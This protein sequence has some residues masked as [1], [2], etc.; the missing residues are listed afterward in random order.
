MSLRVDVRANRD[1]FE[2]DVAFE[3]EPGNTVALLGPN[4]SGK[5][6]LVS[7]LAGLLSP[8]EGI[9]HLEDRVLDD[10]AHGVHVDPEDRSVGVVFQDRLLLPHLDATE[11]VAFPLRA[12][13][14]P[15]NEALGRARALLSDLG[16]EARASAMPAELSGGEAQ[17]VALA[18]ALASRP[19]LLLLDEP[20]SALDVRTRGRT[21]ALVADSLARFDGVRVLVTHDP[22]EAM[23]LADRIVVLE[24]GRVTQTGSPAEIRRAPHTPYIGELVGVNLFE[25]RL[26]PLETGAGRLVTRSGEIVVAWPA[27]APRQR[28]DGVLATLRPAD[29]SLHAE[30]PEGSA[31]NVMSGP[32]GAIT[33]EGER[34]RVSVRT[35]PPIVAEIT[36]GSIDRL[37]LAADVPVWLSFKAVEVALSLP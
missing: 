4:G 17:R 5:S 29:V 21:R 34:A 19:A 26:E 20:L 3:I 30:R 33:L 14:M 16:V 11:N 13:G 10:A 37:G 6:T 12:R 31:R 23:T 28:I 24:H 2:L 35:A 9:V 25:G 15:R 18:R 7:V 36:L 8:R 27:E 22:V 32:V 1:A